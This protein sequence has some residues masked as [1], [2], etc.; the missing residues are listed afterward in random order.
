[1]LH[2]IHCSTC[3]GLVDKHCIVQ[4][5]CS[6]R[7]LMFDLN[8]LQKD[9]I[10]VYEHEDYSKLMILWAI[11]QL[12]YEYVLKSLK[13]YLINDYILYKVQF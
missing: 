7:C 10:R 12:I 6:C 11:K 2:P 9:L 1:M 4:C 13:T 3:D 8:L 5:I